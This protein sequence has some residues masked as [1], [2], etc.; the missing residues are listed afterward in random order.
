MVGTVSRIT[1]IKDTLTLI[2]AAN[3][4]VKKYPTKFVIVGEVQ[5]EEYYEECLE[6]VETLGIKSNVVFTGFQ[7]S[8]EWY[9]KFDVFVLP[10]LSE[11]FPLTI[12]EALSSG[13]PCLAT[14]VGGVPEILDDEFLVERWDYRGLSTKISWLL[15]N[16]EMRYEIGSRGRKLV[17]SK[18]NVSKMVEEYRDL[19]KVMA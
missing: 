3:D 13:V 1:P 8:T 19:Y 4:V 11:G 6:L 7:D 9:P 10:S 16:P 12:L 2:R 17:E 14:R 5:D 18:F 15:R